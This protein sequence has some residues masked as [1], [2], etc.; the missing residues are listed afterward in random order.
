MIQ[1]V[2][3]NLAYL[4]YPKNVCPW[5]ES[6]KYLQTFEYKRLQATIDFFDSD[7]NKKLRSNIKEEFEKDF[8]LKD[9]EDFS[10]LDYQ[11]RCF[12]FF[13]NVFENGKLHSITLYLSILSPY[14]TIVPIVHSA[15]PF[16][17][18]SRI[19]EL[20]MENVDPR[21]L[22]DLILDVEKIVESKLYYQKFPKELIHTI[23]DDI[24]FQG[25]YLGHF[26]MYNAF[27][28]NESI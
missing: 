18:Q 24:S 17:S 1:T 14:Y 7:E 2:L 6:E 27:F 23:I 4:F 3:T 25:I 12:K 15:S 16:F 21:K 13:L 22:N 28:N 11:D 26:K 10:R 8:I 20:E 9:F 5:N 19:D